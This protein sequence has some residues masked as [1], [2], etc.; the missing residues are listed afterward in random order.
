MQRRAAAGSRR[1]ARAARER[2]LIVAEILVK[3]IRGA[4]DVEEGS[5]CRLGGTFCASGDGLFW[6]G[7]A[8]RGKLERYV[9]YDAS[10]A[11]AV[12]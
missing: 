6:T 11:N 1:P 3:M 2:V 7:F 8:R 4:A 10:Q 9:T 12:E 5:L